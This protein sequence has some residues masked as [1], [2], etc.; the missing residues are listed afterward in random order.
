MLTYSA[1]SDLGRILREARHNPLEKILTQTV[2]GAHLASVLRIIALDGR[3]LA[4]LPKSLINDNLAADRT[5]SLP[6]AFLTVRFVTKPIDVSEKPDHHS[7]SC[8]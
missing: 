3:G 8:Q 5:A 4:W 1:E 7:E 6:W 2:V